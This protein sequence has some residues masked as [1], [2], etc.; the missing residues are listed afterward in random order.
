MIIYPIK[1]SAPILELPEP[2]LSNQE[3]IQIMVTTGQTVDNDVY[4][5]IKN[6]TRKIKKYTFTWSMVSREVT[7]TIM[8]YL[9]QY[10][11]EEFIFINHNGYKASGY[12]ISDLVF[13]TTNYS[14]PCYANP[15]EDS[16][17]ESCTFT[18]EFYDNGFYS[19]PEM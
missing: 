15:T 13:T 4:T 5:Y 12:L 11:H 6:K 14:P 9:K 7:L 19:W 2:N 18:L 10:I 17:A 16:R 3:Y 8:A 1:S